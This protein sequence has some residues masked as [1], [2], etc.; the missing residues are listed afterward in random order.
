VQDSFNSRLRT[1]S[2]IACCMT[3]MACSN[4]DQDIPTS[5]LK[6][7]PLAIEADTSTFENEL[8]DT[9]ENTVAVTA[10]EPVVEYGGNM[11][12]V[13]YPKSFTPRPL[14]PEVEVDTW[15]FIETDEAFFKSADGEVEFFVFSPQWAGDPEWY[16][17]AQPNEE[18]L[19]EKE[20]VDPHNDEN[21]KY[22][23]TFKAL[24]GSY[25]RSLYSVKTEFN[26]HHVFGIQY[27]DEASLSAYK[28]QYEAFKES[29]IQFADA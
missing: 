20:S 2:I 11:F 7:D 4:A 15:K 5:G 16:M 10:N 12:T 14:S 8:I 29:L 18:L 9:V 21:I 28:E 1:I 6:E 22:W 24:D 26:T 17:E 19:S 3:I 25:F 27:K 13:K 23:A